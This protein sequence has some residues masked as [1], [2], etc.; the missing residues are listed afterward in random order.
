MKRLLYVMMLCLGVTGFVA[1]SVDTES[2]ASVTIPYEGQCDS[3]VFDNAQDTVFEQ[4]IKDVIASKTIPLVG[5]N[6]AFSESFTTNDGV[7]Q[8]AV[9]NCNLQALRTYETMV[10]NVSSRMMRSTMETLYGDSVNFSSLGYYTVY[11]SLYGFVNERNVQIGR[12]YKG[13]AP[14]E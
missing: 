13:Y 5:E 9:A 2:E 14:I 7:Y 12:T 10:N 3:I 1:C 6:S 4:Y 11:Y 8:N